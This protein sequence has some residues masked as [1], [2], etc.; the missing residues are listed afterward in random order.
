MTKSRK[1]MVAG[2][3]KMNGSLALLTAFTQA[4]ELST[5]V[6][7]VLCVPF[8]YLAAAGK[9]DFAIGA[10]DC[11]QF[12]SGAH[13]GDIAVSML[14]ELGVEYVI[15]GHS[16]RRQDHGESNE[17]IA[18]KVSTVLKAGLTPILCVGEPL[19]LR[20]SNTF[21]EYVLEQLKAVDEICGRSAL[22]QCV[23]AY[24]PIWAIGTGM[25]ATPEQAQEVHEF[26]RTQI[27]DWCEAAGHS[28]IL[29]GGSVNASNAELLFAKPD[30]DGGLIGGASLKIEDFV[31]ICNAAK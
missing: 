9:G 27:S 11:S 17:D 29:Y 24:E 31:V 7:K 1:P 5:V 30:I 28:R 8:P 6:D 10:Q 2:N 20:Q 13:T 19:E 23:I 22:S 15:V 21:K 14:K 16:E 18:A 3:W 12:E 25:T 26:I 4:V